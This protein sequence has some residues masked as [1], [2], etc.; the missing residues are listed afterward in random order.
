MKWQP[1]AILA[2]VAVGIGAY[3]YFVE[4][5]KPQSAADD[6]TVYV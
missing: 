2:V 4:R 3:I 5:P 1:T 6:K